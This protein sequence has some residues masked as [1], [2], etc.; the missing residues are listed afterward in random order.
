MMG[1]YGGRICVAD[2]AA[3]KHINSLRWEIPGEVKWA[4]AYTTSLLCGFREEWRLK[5]IITIIKLNWQVAAV[6]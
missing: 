1:E 6:R 4:A 2:A 3:W 5:M